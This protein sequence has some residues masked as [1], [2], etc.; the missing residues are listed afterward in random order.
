[1]QGDRQRSREIKILSHTQGDLMSISSLTFDLVPFQHDIIS[2]L[3]R[4]PTFEPRI[5]LASLPIPQHSL[6][7]PQTLHVHY[8]VT[9][10]FTRQPRGCHFNWSWPFVM[11]HTTTQLYV[12]CNV[13][14][15]P[16]FDCVKLDVHPS[17][18]CSRTH[19]HSQ[20]RM[21]V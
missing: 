11:L 9:S 7:D 4:T 8:A 5:S 21:Y 14:P 13:I 1:M 6:A 10:Q 17:S 20:W 16:C 18:P 12:N 2:R 19:P 15:R 3:L